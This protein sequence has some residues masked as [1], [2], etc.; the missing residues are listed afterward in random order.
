[1]RKTR[2][3]LVL[4]V[5][6]FVGFLTACTST[7][8]L[9]AAAKDDLVAE[10]ADTISSETYQVTGN[11]DLVTEIGEVAT[12]SWTSSNT[13]VITASG[14]VTRPQADT[15]V[16]LTATLTIEGE[17]ITH[18]FRVTVK[19]A[20]VTTAQKLAAA[21]ALL[22]TEYE[23][24]IGD[25]E[26]VV[27]GNLT[28]VAT[29]GEATVTWATSNAAIVSAAGVVTAPAFSVGD[30]TVTL[31]ATLT[32]GTETTTQIFYAFVEALD[33]TVAERLDRA[34]AFVTTFPAVEGITGAEDWIE[35]PTSVVFETVTYTV[36]WTSDK[37]NV[38]STDG[39]VTRPAVNTPNEKVVMTATITEG[40]VTRSMEK[41]FTVFAIESSQ[42]LDS[43]G[44]VYSV[45]SGTYVKFEGVTVIGKMAGGFFISDGSTMLYIYD[46]TTLYNDVQVGSVYDIEGVY[47]LYFN[48]PQL[49]NDASR[50]LTAK[51][52]SAKPASLNG[53]ASTVSQAIA[54]KPAPSGANLMVYNYLAISGKIMVDG[55]ETVDV[56]RYNTFLVDS[57]YTGTKVIKTLA[58]GKATAYETPAIVVYYQSLNKAA[59][60]ALDG[61]NVTINIL[62]YG[63][64]TDR[65]IWYAV[66]LG[67]GNDIQVA[68]ENDADAVATV[69]SGLTMPG[70]I[71]DATELDLLAAQHGATIE[72]TSSNNAVIDPAT[73]VVTPV[74]G[75]QVTVTL[76]ATIEKG[77]ATDTKVFTIKVGV[78]ALSTI[79]AAKA[80]TDGSTIKIK[81]IL[82]A[83]TKTATY[84]MQDATGGINI[85]ASGAAL[86]AIEALALGVEIE[87]VGEL[88]I[89]R[90][91]FGITNIQTV[92]VKNNTPALPTP[93]S[94][95]A[96]EFTNAGLLPF[97]GQLVSFEGFLLK[98]DV[99]ATTSSFNFDL[100]NPVNGKE[101]AARVESSAPGFADIVAYLNPLAVDAPI[102]VVGGIIGWYNNYQLAITGAS[103]LV[104]GTLTDGHKV[105]LDAKA[106]SIPA[107]FTEAGTV[108]LPATGTNG[109]AIAWVSDNALI[110][111]A[112]GAVTM[113][114]SGQVTVTLT[115][116][117][118]L[119]A[120]EK[121]V[122]F[123]VL[124][125]TSSQ[126][127]VFS[128]DLFISYYMEGG[129]NRKVIAIHNNT[130]V[131]VDLSIYKIVV[132]QN[133]TATFATN[134]Y[135]L[136][137]TLPQ[138]KT[139]VANHSE[140]RTV[141]T[142]DIGV[143]FAAKPEGNLSMEF[144]LGYNGAANDTITLQKN[145]V[146]IDQ[147]GFRVSE[148]AT[149]ATWEADYM[150]NKT[151]IRKATVLGPTTTTNWTEW[152]VNPQDYAS[153]KLWTWK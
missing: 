21:K 139:I 72:W 77:T 23:D 14:V 114:A 136:A 57:T 149:P 111:A 12:V 116:T 65:N 9:L 95:N 80:L 135:Q 75:E 90:G 127:E 55:Q 109:S 5:A 38:L 145:D 6:L 13:A 24:T 147:I 40:T 150:A 15:V 89:Y 137:G 130:G 7:E 66:Y 115:A 94:L 84:W 126:P 63:W 110:N 33:E 148:T 3:L 44:E 124:L 98:A 138:G 42:L 69:K 97:Q 61:K 123:D 58:S 107:T 118:T 125:G 37:P 18:Q 144:S 64:R 81:G 82:S 56:G 47:G 71:I 48:A 106:I 31:T 96:V 53:V 140:V 43:I 26:Y 131:A 25:D 113:P 101:I 70:S 29:I 105:A 83:K 93:A 142:T 152:E 11:L 16:T 51:A 146:I 34:L 121:V 41:E 132:Y 99:N 67:D 10:Y 79:A 103:N 122:T 92:S 74:V 8:D 78:P 141:P 91:L 104:N 22:V 17:T 4:L 36:S 102:N 54:T 39:T 143:I 133:E 27:T 2:V 46:T 86:T 62:L 30:Q 88:D 19:A 1:M 119:N 87:L 151:L 45:D 100:Y 129:S 35:F 73:G 108:T 60:E 153:S 117:V 134:T 128:T 120:A 49:A 59:V 32:I 76:T 52:S 68:F 85:Y 28:L 112:T 50:P 20:E